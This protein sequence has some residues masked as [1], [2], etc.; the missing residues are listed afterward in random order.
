MRVGEKAKDSMWRLLEW[1]FVM[2]VLSWLL[3]RMWN[4][5]LYDRNRPPRQSW[6]RRFWS[7][8]LIGTSAARPAPDAIDRPETTR[9][10]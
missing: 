10:T 2:G 1:S 5:S 7:S 3:V 9:P 6:I 4:E 8:R